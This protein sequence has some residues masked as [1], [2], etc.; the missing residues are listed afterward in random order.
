MTVTASTYEVLSLKNA[1][2]RWCWDALVDQ[3]PISDVYYRPGYARANQM[4]DD[5]EA[6]GL[7]LRADSVHILVPLLLRPLS[8]LP[9]ANDEHGLDAITPYGY[10]GLLPLGD[11]QPTE[12]DVCVLLDELRHWCREAGVVT[13]LIR[14]HPLL[15]Q[16]G[17]LGQECWRD[18]RCSLQP[19][20]STIGL[21]LG[22]WDVEQHRLAG[23]HK[24]RRAALNR[25]RRHL[26]VTWS[27]ADLPLH[28]A[29]ALF[30]EMYE[31]RMTLLA[32]SRDY[33]FS[34]DYYNSLADALGDNLGVA[35][36]W[37]NE[38]LVGASMFLADRHFAHYHLSGSSEEGRDLEAGTL[39]INAGALW[40]RDRGCRMLHL[41]GGLGDGDG[42]FD[43]KRSFGGAEYRYH[44]LQVVAD[45]LRYR[46]LV[47]KHQKF[48]TQCKPRTG[49]FPEYRA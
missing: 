29:L 2:D 38:Q 37:L 21:N 13:C 24:N 10:G 9:F 47:E 44:T 3:A 36:A 18:Q 14:L 25:A 15:E 48:E 30:R 40:A 34:S 42:L 11:Q 46:D 7:V 27:G 4:A 6:V 8:N 28:Q 43:Y 22:R 31:Q 19:R 39:L 1:S 33:F 49:F 12:G 17:W 35:L 5:G 45:E 41:G 26:R 16:D 23:L 20:A 32:A